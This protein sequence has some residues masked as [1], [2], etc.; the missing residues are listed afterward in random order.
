MNLNLK[1]N[2]DGFIYFN[3]LLHASL[4]LYYTENGMFDDLNSDALKTLEKAEK[5]FFTKLKRK[6]IEE[7]VNKLFF[8]LFIFT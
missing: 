8:L 5:M 7:A 2:N 6:K 4:K 1:N 3:E